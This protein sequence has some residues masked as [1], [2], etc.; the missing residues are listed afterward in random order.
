MC[1]PIA[2]SRLQSS[3]GN[4][5]WETELC[6]SLAAMLIGDLR[7]AAIPQ[8]AGPGALVPEQARQCQLIVEWLH[9]RGHLHEAPRECGRVLSS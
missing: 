2:C 7:D 3:S 9:L 6:H 4:V 1:G 8:P 5:S